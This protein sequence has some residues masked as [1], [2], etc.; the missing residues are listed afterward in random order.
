V[1]QY[2]ADCKKNIFSLQVL[3]VFHEDV[4]HGDDV[5]DGAG[6]D[7]EMEH[8][9][10]VFALVE[11]VEDG[12]RDVAHALGDNPDDGA[13]GDAVDEGFEGDEHTEAHTHE[14][15]G[16]EIAV[17]L[18]VDETADG[19]GDG[20]RPDED[21][22]CPAPVALGAHG[23]EGDGRIGTGDVPIDGGMVPLAQP[24]LPDGTGG[25]GVIN[26][27]GDVRH[28]H[29]HEVE[30]HTCRGPTVF[31]TRA[32]YQKYRAEN[33][34]EGYATGMRPGIPQLFLVREMYLHFHV[35]PNFATKIMLY[36]HFGKVSDVFRQFYNFFYFQPTKLPLKKERQN[37]SC[38]LEYLYKYPLYLD[39]CRM[40]GAVIIRMLRMRTVTTGEMRGDIIGKSR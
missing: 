24:L 8:G 36:F 9:V 40:R 4:P 25:E 7:E 6:K 35:D 39:Y 16:F 18:D 5:A 20:A 34:A 1:T 14:T 17:I 23:D 31:G 12:T 38:K 2:D 22:E 19:A 15:D 30:Y 29:P 37:S 13:R 21:E 26:G 3:N 11:T 10:H 27:G 32:P 28:Q 33:H